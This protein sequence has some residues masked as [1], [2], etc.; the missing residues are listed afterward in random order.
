MGRVDSKV[1]MCG[2]PF[3]V[4]EEEH[5]K[6]PASHGPLCMNAPAS[7]LSLQLQASESLLTRSHY[8]PGMLFLSS[9]Q[10]LAFELQ[11]TESQLHLAQE[12]KWFTF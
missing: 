7:N 6:E 9:V 3:R 8:P 10:S 2:G 12:E 5:V 4:E 1:E 11:N